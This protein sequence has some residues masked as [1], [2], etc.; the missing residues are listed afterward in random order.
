MQISN[1]T[2]PNSRQ[3]IPIELLNHVRATTTTQ[4]QI[5]QRILLTSIAINTSEISVNETSA[6]CSFFVL[7]F[8]FVFFFLVCL[9]K[10]Y[11]AN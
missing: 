3:M 1:Q 5:Q 6:F 2:P 9:L 7:R 8:E 10:Q 11:F 4:P